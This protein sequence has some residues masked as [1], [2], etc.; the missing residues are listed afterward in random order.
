MNRLATTPHMISLGRALLGPI[1]LIFL[2]TEAYWALAVSLVIV[3][4][5]VASDFFDGYLAR[6]QESVGELGRYIDGASDAIF[7]IGVF[8]GFLANGWLPASWFLMIYVAE[9]VVPYTGAF[10]KQIG[11]PIDIRWSARLKTVVH[12]AT[13]LIMLVTALTLAEP[14]SA[15]DTMFGIA[16]LGA[17]VVASFIYVSDHVFLAIWRTTQLA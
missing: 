17:A 9:I 10:A 8:L 13:Q 5:A 2:T 1:I 15:G 4:I 3:V 11:H 6:Q 16:A 7:N 14:G 12:P